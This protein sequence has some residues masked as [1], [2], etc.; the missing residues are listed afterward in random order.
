MPKKLQKSC[1]TIFVYLHNPIDLITMNKLYKRK[2]YF[3]FNVLFVG[4]ELKLNCF[5]KI[6]INNSLFIVWST[7]NWEEKILY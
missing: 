4:K 1:V 6:K 2:N 7:W 3:I 5:F